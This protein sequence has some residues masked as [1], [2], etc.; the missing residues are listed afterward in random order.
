MLRVLLAGSL[1]WACTPPAEPFLE[2]AQ[3]ADAPVKDAAPDPDAG[4]VDAEPEQDAEPID[5]GAGEDASL[6]DAT[7]L[8][9]I[10]VWT[11]NLRNGAIEGDV[12]PRSQIVIDAINAE[13]PDLL[14][15][16]EV[17]QTNSIENVAA[18]IA[19]GTGYDHRWQLM[20]DAVAFE[21]GVAV[22]SRHP[23]LEME[24]VVLPHMDL[25]IFQRIVL[26]VRIDHPSG[27]IDLFCGHTTTSDVEVEKADQQKAALEF[28]R[29]R[30]GGTLAIYGGDLNARP[31]TLA[32]QMLRGEATHDG[33]T[34]DLV[35]SWMA[36]HPGEEG[37]T[38]EAG[39]PNRRIDYLYAVPGVAPE[40]C[41]ILF[42]Q[43]VSGL[44]A[45]DHYGVGCRFRVE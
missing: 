9:P 24:H 1:L 21:E 4:A 6:Q 25:V 33:V 28:I 39:D 27:A 42:D 44:Y 7:P 17:V 29:A 26:R 3:P 13:T 34:G 45:S 20:N 35:D 8:D 23:I 32:M 2:D 16:Q 19:A 10:H 37:L 38:F 5:A 36:T 22:L 15:F 12:E 30:T 43:Q 14:C 41:R 40:E 31:D 18:S 11:F